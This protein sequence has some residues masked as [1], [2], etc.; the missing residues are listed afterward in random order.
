M[1]QTVG[2]TKKKT[3]RKK[4]EKNGWGE[5]ACKTYMPAK[6]VQ[7]QAPSILDRGKEG[8]TPKNY[9]RKNEKNLR[10]QY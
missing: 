2:N 6:S 1:H 5:K 9:N 3:T 8:K 4:G 10:T 7:K